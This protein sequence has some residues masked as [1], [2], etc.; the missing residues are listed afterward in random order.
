MQW[1][2]AGLVLAA[3]V[4]RVVVA[5]Y[6]GGSALGWRRDIRA[7]TVPTFVRS[8]HGCYTQIDS[9]SDAMRRV[10]RVAISRSQL[11]CPQYR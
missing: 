11:V 8:G 5:I 6:G 10:R 1:A 3:L 9:H 7:V 2:D 4:V